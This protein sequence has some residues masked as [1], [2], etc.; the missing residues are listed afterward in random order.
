[1]EH[2]FEKNWTTSK[3]NVTLTHFYILDK[4]HVEEEVAKQ[5]QT[6]KKK[7]KSTWRIVFSWMQISNE[8]SFFSFP[9]LHFDFVQLSSLLAE[10]E[11]RKISLHDWTFL[12]YVLSFWSSA[13]K[14]PLNGKH[15][16]QLKQRR[17]SKMIHS[18]FNAGF[19]LVIMKN[20]HEIALSYRFAK[21]CGKAKTIKNVLP[22]SAMLNLWQHRH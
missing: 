5:C 13:K 16:S 11:K 17:F 20:T 12:H 6:T 3:F 9:L 19:L 14:M 15:F 10:L 8:T 22:A 21:Q 7:K 4:K 2:F 1:M 18:V